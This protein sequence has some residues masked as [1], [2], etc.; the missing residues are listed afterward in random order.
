MIVN[1][2]EQDALIAKCARLNRMWL[3]RHVCAINAWR[4]KYPHL[5][6]TDN[7]MAALAL[8]ALDGMAGVW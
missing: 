8:V 1:P 2:N 3:L 4:W 6:G 7:Q 5:M